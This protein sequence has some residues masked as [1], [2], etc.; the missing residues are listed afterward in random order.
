MKKCKVIVNDKQH[1]MLSEI[2][3]YIYITKEGS[4][5]TQKIID[6]L[7][8]SNVLTQF[9]GKTEM[10]STQ[11]QLKEIRLV[12]QRYP[13]L[14]N[15]S[16]EKVQKYSPKTGHA[17]NIYKV[18]IS[19][20]I[21]NS[22]S[23]VKKTEVEIN[24]CFKQIENNILNYFNNKEYSKVIKEFEENRFK[25]WQILDKKFTYSDDTNQKYLISILKNFNKNIEIDEN[26]FLFK[27][28]DKAKLNYQKKLHRN[29]KFTNEEIN[30]NKL[31]IY[32]EN[33]EFNFGKNIGFTIG[34]ISVQE[35]QY[36]LWCIIN[37]NHFAID[38]CIFTE[39]YFVKC[40]NFHVGLQYNLIKNL[41]YKKWKNKF[42][43]NNVVFD[44]TENYSDH[45]YENYNG[46]Y[47]QDVEGWS[48]QDIWDVFDGDP[49]AYWN[50]D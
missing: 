11:E 15:S 16:F 42:D 24:D 22:A 14:L 35:P 1:L 9:P 20:N 31:V 45:T 37:L 38:N 43:S 10:F 18:T 2:A 26:H 34:E 44:T 36:I 28:I 40:Y 29:E 32:G 41:V 50:I 17:T 30:N 49:D 6:I 27:T 21:L 4:R 23:E 25:N 39:D 19:P 7:K 13:G 5:S 46:S 12:N 3:E 33:T 47:A 48:D 8:D